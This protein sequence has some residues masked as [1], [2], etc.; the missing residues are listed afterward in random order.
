MDDYQSMYGVELEHF[1]GRYS[2]GVAAYRPEDTASFSGDIFGARHWGRF[3]AQGNLGYV[4][5][6]DDTWTAGAGVGLTFHP[7]TNVRL[8]LQA[9]ADHVLG[10]YRVRTDEVGSAI[11][12]ES[13]GCWSECEPPEPISLPASYDDIDMIYRLQ[14]GLAWV[15]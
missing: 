2:F 4:N 15:F 1:K 14:A 6:P 5:D 13:H 9:R 11:S 10:D 12:T 3:F 8:K 7:R